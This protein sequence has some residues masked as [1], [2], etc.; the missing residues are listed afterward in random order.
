VLGDLAVWLLG[1]SGYLF[2]VFLGSKQPESRQIG[3][4]RCGSQDK[5]RVDSKWN[6]QKAFNSQGD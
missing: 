3:A 6:I 1:L 4:S 2:P 5:A